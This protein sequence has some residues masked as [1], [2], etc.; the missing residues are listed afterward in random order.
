MT[1]H[2]A[3]FRACMANPRIAIP[4]LKALLPPDLVGMLVF[5][6]I[7]VESGS[8]VSPDLRERYSDI[9]FSIPMADRR[10]YIYILV[11]HQ[12]TPDRRMPFRIRFYVDLLWIRLQEEFGP[13]YFPLIYPLV[14]YNGKDPYRAPRTMDALVT[15]P[16]TVVDAM[17]HGPLHIV[18]LSETEDEDLRGDPWSY[19]MLMLMKHI[20]TPEVT[21]YLLDFIPELRQIES[22]PGGREFILR[23]IE[24]LMSR[25]DAARTDLIRDIINREL[26]GNARKDIMTIA[27]R[28][29]EQGRYEG[30]VVIARNLINAGMDLGE[31]SEITG[32]THEETTKVKMGHSMRKPHH[33]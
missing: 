2:D 17:L 30:S 16:R 5:S 29:R 3:F 27:D 20:N 23:A 6:K 8:F 7:R 15:G 10:L 31:V 24:Y 33:W 25:G 22:E 12:S 18:D 32:L 11:E 21:N 28:L 19:V 4:V 9:H 13:G 14:I 1:K 26:V